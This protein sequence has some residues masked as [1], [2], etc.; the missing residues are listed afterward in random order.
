MGLLYLYLLLLIMVVGSVIWMMARRNDLQVDVGLS[1]NCWIVI[2]E[3]IKPKLAECFL[4]L[5]S[6][7]YLHG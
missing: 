4:K 1:Q 2:V 3:N 5:M 7:T 6:V